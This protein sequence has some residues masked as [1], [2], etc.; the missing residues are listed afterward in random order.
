MP[1]KTPTPPPAAESGV[2]AEQGAEPETKAEP[3]KTPNPALAWKREKRRRT[4]RPAVSIFSLRKIWLVPLVAEFVLM[5]GAGWMAYCLL[6]VTDDP[7]VGF[8]TGSVLVFAGLYACLRFYAKFNELF[9]PR[10]VVFFGIGSLLLISLVTEAM[11]LGDAFMVGGRSR[12]GHVALV[13]TP[14]H[15]F[16]LRCLMVFRESRFAPAADALGIRV[17]SKGTKISNLRRRLRFWLE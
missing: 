1:D 17:Q 15:L 16:V 2:K 8:P 14:I 4:E 10:K 12:L 7:D 11:V 3:G 6:R 13:L 9:L 5:L